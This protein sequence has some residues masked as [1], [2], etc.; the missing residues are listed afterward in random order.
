M[1]TLPLLTCAFLLFCTADQLV[2]EQEF[3]DFQV[4]DQDC[5]LALLQLSVLPPHFGQFL[6]MEL[7]Q[8][9]LDCF[10]ADFVHENLPF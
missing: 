2:V 5:P 6:C 3:F 1:Y 9:T 10:F 7:I 4:K 8:C